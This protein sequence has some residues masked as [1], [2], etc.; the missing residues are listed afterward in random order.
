VVVWGICFILFCFCFVLFFMFGAWVYW[1]GYVWAFFTHARWLVCVFS[2]VEFFGC[3]Y[4]FR[5]PGL[6]KPIAPWHI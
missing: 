4:L 3:P 2:L 1:W 5:F 6:N